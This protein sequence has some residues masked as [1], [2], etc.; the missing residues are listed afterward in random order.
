M[1]AGTEPDPTPT[2]KPNRPGYDPVT[3]PSGGGGYYPAYYKVTVPDEI[4]G[5]TLAS[6]H[7]E[8]AAGTT[9]T[10]TAKPE[11]GYELDMVTAAMKSGQK[12]ELTDIGGGAYTF[13]MPAGDVD[14]SASYV[15][16]EEPGCKR[17]ESCPIWPFTD[18]STTA[19]YHDGVHYC[20]ERGLMVGC[21]NSLFKPNADTSRAMLTAMLWRLSGSPEPKAPAQF[22][23]VSPDRWYAKAIA[24]ASE[25]G[26]AVGYGGKRFGPED[27]LT[28]EQMVAILWRYAKYEGVDVT[29]AEDTLQN[30]ADSDKVSAYAV[31]AVRWAC[32]T[33]ILV[34]ITSPDGRLLDPQGRGSRAQVAEVVMR[35]AEQLLDQA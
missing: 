27:P 5:G 33:G 17:D 22:T 10:L 4:V 29:P 34:G 8:A 28:R 23:D 13:K 16:I 15:K 2:P 19:W 12:V 11:D 9:V 32:G 30:F 6:S 14:A 24:W 7:R 20:L 21:G 35:Y 26:V 1:P 25:E 31:P 3:P 18:A